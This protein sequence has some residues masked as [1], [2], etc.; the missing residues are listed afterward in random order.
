MWIFRETIKNLNGIEQIIFFARK[1]KFWTRKLFA[2]KNLPMQTATRTQTHKAC[3]R[4]RWKIHE[5]WVKRE[6]HARASV[7]KNLRSRSI[8]SAYLVKVHFNGEYLLSEFIVRN[9]QREKLAI[10]RS[11]ASYRAAVLPRRNEISVK[12]CSRADL[13]VLTRA[14]CYFWHKSYRNIY[15]ML[16]DI[17][18]V[19]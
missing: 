10:I 16:T 19:T 18:F 8:V 3:I 17:H 7:F 14:N 13:P 6:T 5:N 11:S 2:K 1:N 9:I 15:R 12:S 4:T